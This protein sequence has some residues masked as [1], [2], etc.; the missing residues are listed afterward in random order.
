LIHIVLGTKAQLIK[1]APIMRRLQDRKIPYNFIHTGQHRATMPEMLADF[2]LRE[3]DVLLHNGAD[4]VSPA[5]MF[6]WILGILWKTVFF[7]KEIFQ[8]QQGIVLVHGDTFSTLL[9]ALMG[10]LAG[11][12]VGHVESGLRSFN[13]LHPFPEEITRLFV[14]RLSHILYCPGQWAMD[15]VVY[16]KREKVNIGENTLVDTLEMTLKKDRQQG[17]AVADLPDRPFAM[18]SLHRYENIFKEKQLSLVV[19]H[20]EAI[21]L[22]MFLLFIL[23]PATEKQLCAFQLYNRVA[24][25]PNIECRHRYPHSDFVALLTEAEFVVTDGGSL[26]E[27]ASYLGIP[28]LL[29]RKATERREGL[30]ENVLLSCYEPQ[31]IAD[32]TGHYQDYVRPVRTSRESPS[33]MVIDSALAHSG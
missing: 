16:L 24:E 12:R 19:S 26:Q 1:M 21:A 22:K 11:L 29:L 30:G 18:V 33:D 5:R 23:H 31:R 7:R 6:G 3:P 13:L 17:G 32:F 8:A 15:N 9:G 14:F 25:N 4:V 10:R 27:E 2:G 20:I 28:C